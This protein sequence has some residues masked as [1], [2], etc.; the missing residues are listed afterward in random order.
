MAERWPEPEIHAALERLQRAV[1]GRYAVLR[2]LGQGGMGLVFLARD[3]SLDRPVAIKVLPDA[4]AARA[5][6]RERFV[7]EA[8]TAAQLAHPHIVPIHSVEGHGE[9]VF[10]VMTFVEGETLGERVR[11]AGPLPPDEALRIG[12]EVSWAL[13]YA[14]QRGVIH[15]DVKPD[16]ILLDRASGRALVSDFGI[17]LPTATAATP[18]ERIE[19]TPRYM[20]P[21]QSAGDAQDGRSDLYS[22]GLVLHFALTGSLPS[23]GSAALPPARGAR[24]GEIVDR[25]LSPAPDGRFPNGEALAVALGDAR[26]FV[27][28]TP[29]AVRATLE[30]LR[31]FMHEVSSYVAIVAVLLVAIL[32]GVAAPPGVVVTA[33]VTVLAVMSGLFIGRSSQLVGRIRHLLREGFDADDLWRALERDDDRPSPAIG[34]RTAVLAL[35]GAIGWVA[36]LFA[37]TAGAGPVASGVVAALL[38]LY[39]MMV[40]R[41][42]LQRLLAPRATGWWKRFR[43]LFEWKFFGMAGLGLDRGARLGPERTEQALAE[44]AREALAGLGPERAAVVRLVDG[45]ADRIAELRSRDDPAARARRDEATRALEALRLALLGT[46]TGG[47]PSEELTR[48]IARARALS[49][50]IDALIAARH[51]LDGGDRSPLPTP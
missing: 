20:S 13:A 46:T 39:P 17:A 37:P 28:P 34:A 18:A 2:P 16:N 3:L 32:I 6:L 41:G 51:E 44:S 45:L 11:R 38:A 1:A 19:G 42:L 47:P 24:L 26:G 29:A 9:L 36:L 33:A 8:R 4:L 22:L 50:R 49:E 31:T 10:F 43:R 40:L 21:E 23:T 12:Q 30:T 15:R 7:R 27:A 48:S 25:L 5:D 14:H 35:A